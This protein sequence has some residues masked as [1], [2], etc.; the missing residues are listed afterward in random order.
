MNKLGIYF[1]PQVISI[2]ESKNYQLI[3]SISIPQSE[4]SSG[5][6]SEEKVPAQLKIINLLKEEFRSKKIEAKEATICL[7]GKDLIIRSFE[8]PI[9]PRQELEGAVNFEAR[10]YI[11]FKVEEII[12]DFQ[13]K[14]DKTIKK[15]HILFVGIK[16]DVL[17]K[18]DNI[19]KGLDL[20][21]S[22]AE[23]SAFS[24]LKMLR[25]SDL[26]DKGIVA[27]VYVDIAENDE[28]SFVVLEDGFPL[29]S[30]DITLF[31]ET[32]KEDADIVIDSSA[33]LLEKLKREIRISLDYYDRIFPLKNINNL[34]F[35]ASR[36]SRMNLE[37]FIKNMGFGVQF[38]NFEKFTTKY[39]G[40]NIPYSLSF[41]K[42]YCSSL[43]KVATP[44]K[45]DL[46]LAKERI[47][48]KSTPGSKVQAFL[49]GEFRQYLFSLGAGLLLWF[50][51]FLFG[52]YRT[53]PLQKRLKA[54]SENK[55]QVSIA[56]IEGDYNL[57]S[58]AY[59]N[60]GSRIRAIRDVLKE[61]LYVSDLLGSIPAILPE[62]IWLME[63]SF[64]RR[65]AHADLVLRG[66][67]YAGDSNKELE[68]INI[69]IS[70]LKADPVFSA[71]FKNID[72]DSLDRRQLYDSKLSATN[73][74]IVCKR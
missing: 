48:R 46:L 58:G 41:I 21:V 19:L 40:K 63:F 67:S 29:F 24:V 15:Y 14:L 5:I 4:I 61:Q 50:L 42:G 62:D 66:V 65:D 60:Y 36:D 38:V 34:F 6:L 53:V 64:Q 10:K 69:F 18:Y 73:F 33:A 45:I 2:V 11:P 22:A 13:Y 1:G 68:I 54:A 51:I 23:Y 56:P 26:K 35:I 52:I 27:N 20:K 47:L 3:N 70:G 59:N 74:T 37:E 43:S 17:D 28:V 25:L 8:V 30:R 44:V 31:S 49:T 72:I 71:Y 12:F 16:K 39:I 9:L 7:S 32:K 57:L 55:P